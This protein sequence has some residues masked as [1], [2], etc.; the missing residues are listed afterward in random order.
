MSEILFFGAGSKREKKQSARVSLA[1][2]SLGRANV[3]RRGLGSEG[4]GAISFYRSNL[5]VCGQE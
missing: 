1:L 4:R 5:V 3:S 2:W